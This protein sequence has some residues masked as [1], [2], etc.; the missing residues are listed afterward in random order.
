MDMQ[1]KSALEAILSVAQVLACLFRVGKARRRVDQDAW[2]FHFLRLVG[3]QNRDIIEC[4]VEWSRRLPS[5]QGYEG[6]GWPGLGDGN[7]NR[8]NQSGTDGSSGSHFFQARSA[9]DVGCCVGGA[10][11]GALG[12]S[13]EISAGMANR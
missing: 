11:D 1:T 7:N 10:A 5:H 4:A 6:F 3:V 13:S 9:A 2:P 8:C 12:P